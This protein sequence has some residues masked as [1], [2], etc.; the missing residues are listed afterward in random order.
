MDGREKSFVVVVQCDQAVHSVCPGFLCEHAFSARRDAFA[1]YPADR[2]MRYMS[3][4]CGGCPGRATERK[5]VNLARNLKKRESLS[6]DAVIVH[7]SSCITNSNHHGPR[8]PHIDY[9][10]GQIRLAGF[11]CV[12]GSRYSPTAEKRRAEGMYGYGWMHDDGSP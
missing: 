12:E 4:S 11:D 1:A 7:L 10:K 9:I 6:S 2:A 3:I 8:C 5:L